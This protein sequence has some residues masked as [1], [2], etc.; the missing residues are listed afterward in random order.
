MIIAIWT[1]AGEAGEGE[2]FVRESGQKVQW[3]AVG[4]NS[5]FNNTLE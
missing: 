5:F 1:L 2:V 3:D 4:P